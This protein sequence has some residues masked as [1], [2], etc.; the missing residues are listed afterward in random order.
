MQVPD[1]LQQAGFQEYGINELIVIAG[2]SIIEA[3]TLT[4]IEQP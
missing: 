1:T 4:D 3:E 2:G